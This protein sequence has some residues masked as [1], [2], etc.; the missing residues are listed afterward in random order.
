MLFIYEEYCSINSASLQMSL[1]GG[2]GANLVYKANLPSCF[3]DIAGGQGD[4]PL[5][6]TVWLGELLIDPD[7]AVGC[8][9]APE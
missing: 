2:H 3:V 9:G 8:L 4:P 5:D 1:Q 6:V 7:V